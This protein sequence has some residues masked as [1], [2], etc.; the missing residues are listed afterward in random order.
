VRLVFRLVSGMGAS[1]EVPV[2]LVETKSPKW[3]FEITLT[4]G[5]FDIGAGKLARVL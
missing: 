1:C 3:A 4:F 5:E 2:R